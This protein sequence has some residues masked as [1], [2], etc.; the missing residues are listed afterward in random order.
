MRRPAPRSAPKPIPRR[1]PALAWRRPAFLWTPA[2][3]VLAIGWPAL[4]LRDDGG[5]ARAVLIAGA[6]TFAV[7]LITLGAA[8]L[9]G[10]APRGRGAVVAHILLAGALCA[11]AAPF[12]LE[13]LLNSLADGASTGPGLR[14]SLPYALAPLALLLGLPITLFSALAFALVALVKPRRA[15]DAPPPSAEANTDDLLRPDPV[16]DVQPF[17]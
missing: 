3:L 2:A 6:A 15:D 9:L 8:W 11:L 4:L 14:A 5:L 1:I 17:R 13:S 10:R 12:V 16:R 7:S